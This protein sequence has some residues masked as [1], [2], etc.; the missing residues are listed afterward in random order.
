MKTRRTIEEI[1]E[2]GDSIN[3]EGLKINGEN[4]NLSIRNI[5]QKYKGRLDL[6]FNNPKN[7]NC[8]YSIVVDKEGVRF[9]RYVYKPNHDHGDVESL[10]IVVDP[11]KVS[12]N[13]KKGD[14]RGSSRF[15]H[16]NEGYNHFYIPFGSEKKES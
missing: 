16:R 10:Q 1:I 15:P 9:E 13:F 14:L 12:G 7:S 2:H 11:E 6:D 5:A 8:E 4:F 3:P